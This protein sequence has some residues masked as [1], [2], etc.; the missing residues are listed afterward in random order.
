MIRFSNPSRS[1]RLIA[2]LTALLVCL[3]ACSVR[4]ADLTLVSTKNIDLSDA[5]LDARKG[6]RHKGEDCA[7][8][9]LG[10]IPF[11]LPNLENAVDKALEAGNGNVIVDEVTEH[12]AYYFVI[13]GMSC[14]SVEGTVLEAPQRTSTKATK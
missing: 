10:L 8:S 7:F 5:Q 2:L 14:L 13:G 9:L 6:T 1:I 12:K 3:V 11:G 4:V